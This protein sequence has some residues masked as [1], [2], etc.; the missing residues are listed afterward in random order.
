MKRIKRL[1]PAL[2]AILCVAAAMGATPSPETDRTAPGPAA[3]SPEFL[4]GADISWVPQQEDEGRRFSVDGTEDD[5]LRI[6][7]SHGFNAVRL[8]LFVD[9][10][11]PGGYSA[12]GYCGLE[13]TV[14]MARRARAAGLSLLLDFHLSD[15]WADPARQTK[16]AAWRELD[17]PGLTN[18]V[19]RHVRD[20]LLELRRRGAA[21]DI[22]QVG[23]EISNGLLWP[24]GKPEAPAKM[25][26]LLKAGIG[27]VREAAPEAKV[28]LH[29]AL[30]GQNRKSRWFLD[31]AARHGVDFDLIG[32]SYYPRWHGTLEDLKANLADLAGRYPQG[33]MV[34]EYST[35]HVR[36]VNE[37]VRGLPNGKGRGT[38]IWEPTHPRHGNLFDGQGRAM[39]A[40]KD[41]LRLGTP[42]TE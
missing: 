1:V 16:P 9:P 36:E 25:A 22:V 31:L 40:L 29:L 14:K 24:D 28:L 12:K 37:I 2:A 35:P 30:G 23:N 38:F 7:K 4:V 27:A 8:R 26:A 41:Y 19:T 42:G 39:P 34:V 5:L 32:Q 3:R 15:T 11:S 10:A 13:S 20:T 6:L 21:P 18:A 33:I 17:F